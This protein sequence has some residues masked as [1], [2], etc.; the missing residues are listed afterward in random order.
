MLLR[1]SLPC[2]Y[3]IALVSV[4]VAAA[5]TAQPKR[6]PDVPYVPTTDVRGTCACSRAR[7]STRN[8]LAN[9]G[10]CGELSAAPKVR[11]ATRH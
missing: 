3:L 11:N 8:T 2:S 6:Q 7:C 4:I 9:G 10:W 1:K 5:Q